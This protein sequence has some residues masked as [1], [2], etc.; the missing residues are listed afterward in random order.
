MT[1]SSTGG[2]ILPVGSPFPIPLE[3]AALDSFLKT[4]VVGITGMDPNY[5]RPRWQPV[6]PP[7]PPITQDWVAVGVQNQQADTNAVVVH[8]QTTTAGVSADVVQRHE[9]FEM[10]CSFYGPGAGE[11]TARLREGLYVAQNRESL[12][13]AGMGLI[14]VGE[15]LNLSPLENT[16]RY[17]RLDMIVYIARNVTRVYPVL[18]LLSSSGTINSNLSQ[19]QNWSTANVKGS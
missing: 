6:A 18:D 14:K 8:R 5:V 12:Q 19:A 11:N 7:Q 2:P 16:Q 15:I 10:L 1:D 4:L 3:D 13:L 9:R 17:R